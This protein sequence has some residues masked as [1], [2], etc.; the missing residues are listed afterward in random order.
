[1]TKTLISV[2]IVVI[3]LIGGLYLYK[4]SAP[5]DKNIPSPQTTTSPDLPKCSNGATN[6]PHCNADLPMPVPHIDSMTPT[7]GPIGTTIEIKGRNLA[8]FEGDLDAY[9]ENEKGETAFLP[10][11]GSVPREDQTIR[12]KIGEKICTKNTGY[13][14]NPCSSYLTVTPGI[15]SIYSAPYGVMSNKVQFTVTP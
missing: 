9:I 1:M 11:I 8:G 14:G 13:S 7:S 2:V 12:V 5:I 6:P 15:Y 10:G 4:A 3:L